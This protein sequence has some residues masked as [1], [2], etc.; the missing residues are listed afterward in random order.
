MDDIL[1]LCIHP[2]QT[3]RA[4]MECIDKNMKGIAMVIDAEQRLLYTMTDGDLRRVVLQ[5]LS[6]DLPVQI[7]ADRRPERGNR[8]PTTMLQGTPQHD[9]L[10]RMKKDEVRHIPLTDASGRIT[11]L[12]LLSELIEEDELPMSAVIMAGGIGRRLYPL[13]QDVPKPMLPVGDRPLLEWTIEQ[14]RKSG[15]RRVNLSTRYKS[16]VISKHFGD[17]QNFGVDIRYVNEDQPLGTAGALSLL[18]SSE[19]PL[20]VVNGD[21]LTRVDFRA[22]RDFHLEQKADMTIAVRPQDYEVPYGVVTTDGARVIGITEKPII[23]HFI[24]AG[25]YLLGPE[26]QRLVPKEQSF[27]MPDLI[28]RLLEMEG[29]VV[30]FPIREYW[31][32]IGHVDHYK[33]ANQD[34]LK[35]KV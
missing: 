21:I 23:R 17:G 4:A 20:L 30:S 16:E 27:D 8:Q 13:T 6:L 2:D 10:A 26:V 31:L 3:L 12:A 1:Q 19:E 15:I 18:G 33:K 11:G 32:D 24:N 7:W 35:G 9:L 25:I 34:L 22:M 28:G 5:G 29:K 14:L